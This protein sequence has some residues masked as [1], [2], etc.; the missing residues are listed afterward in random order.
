MPKKGE[1]IRKRADGRWEGRYKSYCGSDGKMKYRSVYGKSYREVKKKMQESILRETDDRTTASLT[2]AV[3]LKEAAELWQ[4]AYKAMHK[5][6]TE[7]RYAYL[8]EKHILPVLGDLPLHTFSSVQIIH[9][10]NEKLEHG[11]LADAGPLSPRY[12]RA[13]LSVLI[14]VLQYAERENLCGC[15]NVHFQKPSVEK[16]EPAV[17]SV[18]DQKRLEAALL[19]DVDSTKLGILI[20][21]NMGLRIGEVCALTWENI[22]LEKELIHV[23]ATVARVRADGEKCKSKLIID[24]PKTKASVRDIPIPSKLLPSFAAVKKISESKYVLSAG[25]TFI[26]P[27]T[28][29]YRYHKLLQ[30]QKIAPITY[31][32]L[33]HTFATR[34]VEV[35][36]DVKTLSEILGH[37]DVSV[38]LGTY[39]HSSMDLKRQQIEKLSAVSA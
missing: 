38:T 31:H 28:H 3:S 6:A 20:S 5:G 34:C 7:I 13:M 21:L 36:M 22:D 15:L 37:T 8:L 26:S 35:G 29:E 1:N 33:R 18:C 17:L 19:Q 9:F 24:A 30:A 32:E 14:S 4:N 11:R 16:R 2:K 25:D 10:M 23:R 12:V 27:R 39:V